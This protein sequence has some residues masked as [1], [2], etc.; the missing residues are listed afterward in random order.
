LLSVT[1]PNPYF[2]VDS[3]LGSKFSQAR[4]RGL[5]Q[6]SDKSN[7]VFLELWEQKRLISAVFFKSGKSKFTSLK[8]FPGIMKSF[9]AILSYLRMNSFQPRISLFPLGKLPFLFQVA[10]EWNRGNDDVFPLQR[11]RVQATFSRINPIFQIVKTTIIKSATSFQPFKHDNLLV[12]SWV[13]SIGVIHS[14]HLYI[15]A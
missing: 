5:Y 1:I 3:G 7:W 6:F 13:D 2:T 4:A 12:S 9:N 8:S 10:R 15:L 11:A 14:Q